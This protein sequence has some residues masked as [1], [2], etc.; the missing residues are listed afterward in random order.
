M[1]EAA[2]EIERQNRMLETYRAECEG[3]Q[4]ALE[5]AERQRDEAQATADRWKADY[6]TVN[7]A[8]AEAQAAKYPGCKVLSLGDQCPCK[9]CGLERARDEARALLLDIDQWFR[10]DGASFPDY[11]QGRLDAALGKEQ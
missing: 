7:A 1:T 11:I 10:Q 2:D 6:R 5:K 3:W 8:L 9:L 4:A